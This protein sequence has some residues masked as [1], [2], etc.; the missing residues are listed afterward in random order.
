MLLISFLFAVFVRAEVELRLPID[1]VKPPNLREY[2][3]FRDYDNWHAESGYYFFYPEFRGY[4]RYWNQ[5]AYGDIE[6]WLICSSTANDGVGTIPIEF[7]PERDEWWRDNARSTAPANGIYFP[8]LAPQGAHVTLAPM[9]AGVTFVTHGT[10]VYNIDV[11]FQQFNKVHYVQYNGPKSTRCCFALQ[12]FAIY[13]S[14][15][16]EHGQQPTAPN[17]PKHTHDAL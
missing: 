5:R 17:P 12:R 7:P 2:I 13:D 6:P 15:P 3:I 4:V 9:L 11:P 14:D 16:Y 1:L 8:G 10:T